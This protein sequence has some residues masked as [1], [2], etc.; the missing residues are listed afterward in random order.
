MV[1][2][3]SN[4]FS[5]KQ[6]FFLIKNWRKN[7]FFFLIKLKVSTLNESNWPQGKTKINKKKT[8]KLLYFKYFTY[9]TTIIY[10]K[11]KKQTNEIKPKNQ[12]TLFKK[13]S[14]QWSKGVCYRDQIK[15]L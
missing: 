3:N 11:Q 4:L 14:N 10:L 7:F 9:T 13:W 1:F 15:Y 8:A 12:T 5:I 2:L 6:Q